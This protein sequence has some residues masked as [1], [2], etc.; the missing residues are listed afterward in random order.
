MFEITHNNANLHKGFWGRVSVKSSRSPA[1][2]FRTTTFQR[3]S[4]PETLVQ[5]RVVM[6]YLDHLL[7][8]RPD[9]SRQTIQ[10]TDLGTIAG[11]RESLQKQTRNKHTKTTTVV[12]F[13]DLNLVFDGKMFYF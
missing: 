7:V 13:I 12:N 1:E 10:R 6:R 2:C 9:N 3:H 5:I 4:S 8:T 11:A